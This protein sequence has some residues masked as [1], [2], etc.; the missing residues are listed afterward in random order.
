MYDVIA[1]ELLD[2]VMSPDSAA[3]DVW[4]QLHLP[5]RDNQHGRAIILGT[6]F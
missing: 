1:D 5:F 3:Y 4:A 6:E 2:L